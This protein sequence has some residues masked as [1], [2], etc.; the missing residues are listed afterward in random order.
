MKKN[1]AFCPDNSRENFQ[2]FSRTYKQ[3]FPGQQKKSRTFPGC[4]N[5]ATITKNLRIP[6]IIRAGYPLLGKKSS[7]LAAYRYSNKKVAPLPLLE[8]KTAVA[9][10]CPCRNFKKINSTKNDGIQI[11]YLMVKFQLYLLKL[12]IQA[13]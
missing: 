2:I 3:D 10:A 6:S 11:R 7:G 8:C 9:A 12:I 5:P 13:F 4:G 1:F